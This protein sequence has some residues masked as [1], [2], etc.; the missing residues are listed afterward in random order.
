MYKF[1]SCNEKANLAKEA[2]TAKSSVLIFKMEKTGKMLKQIQTLAENNH[3]EQIPSLILE[4]ESALDKA[5]E[6]LSGYLN[7]L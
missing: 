7:E 3:T 2:H 4:V 6:E 5:S 1:L